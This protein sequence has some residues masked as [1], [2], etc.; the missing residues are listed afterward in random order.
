MCVV[1][2]FR[3]RKS[4]KEGVK[5]QLVV[6]AAA[7]APFTTTN[8]FISTTEYQTHLKVITTCSSQARKTRGRECILPRAI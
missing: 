1:D 8:S 6:H 7:A 4:A 2:S 3:I 5:E